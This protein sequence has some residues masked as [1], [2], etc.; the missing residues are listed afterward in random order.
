MVSGLDVGYSTFNLI[1]KRCIQDKQY[2][3]QFFSR[4]ASILRSSVFRWK[5]MFYLKILKNEYWAKVVEKCGVYK[6][7]IF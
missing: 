6:K 5:N 4:I 3:I 2:T 7:Q 1:C